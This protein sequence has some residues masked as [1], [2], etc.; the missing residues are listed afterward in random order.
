MREQLGVKIQNG[1][2]S[3]AIDAKAALLIYVRKIL[4]KFFYLLLQLK[5]REEWEAIL[6]SG[7]VRTIWYPTDLDIF[8][9]DYDFFPF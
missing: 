4:L 7:S 2:H 9:E 1:A 6:A 5:N 8:D 3:P